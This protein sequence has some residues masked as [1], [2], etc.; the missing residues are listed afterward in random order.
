VRRR[1][2]RPKIEILRDVLVAAQQDEK[3]TRIMG[4]ANL[5][6]NSLDKYLTYCVE[7][8]LLMPEN[9]GYR[10]TPR[11]QETLGVIEV[12]LSRGTALDEALRTFARLAGEPAFHSPVATTFF[13]GV[14]APP[15]AERAASLPRNG[16]P[17]RVQG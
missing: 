1:K 4:L 16:T 10:F 11:G 15:T 6:W 12:I 14:D 13:S 3:K 8:G 5:N 2:Y 7:R 17:L 9:G